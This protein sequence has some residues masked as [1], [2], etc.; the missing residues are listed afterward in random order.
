MERCKH[1]LITRNAA[2]LVDRIQEFTESSATVELAALRLNC[3]P[4]H[5]AKSLSFL[6]KKSMSKAE[7]KAHQRALLEMRKQQQQQQQQDGGEGGATATATATPPSDSNVIVIVA[8]G[9]AKVSAKK[10]KDKFLGQPKMLR[11]EEVEAYTGFPPGGV[12]PFGLRDEVKVYLDVSLK[13]FEHVYPAAGSTNTGVR[14]TLD[15]LEQ[16]ASNVVE[17]ADLCEAWQPEADADADAAAKTATTDS[18]SANADAAADAAAAAATGVV[19]GH[20]ITDKMAAN[21]LSKAA[22]AA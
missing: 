22:E 11:R 9:D 2:F 21:E 1:Y 3:E 8:A 4:A 12:C 19:E 6:Q 20:D 13:R 14:V 10:F 7:A 17:W 5:I 18:E 15:E 16:Y